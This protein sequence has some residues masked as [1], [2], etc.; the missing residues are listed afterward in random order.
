MNKILYATIKTLI[1][2]VFLIGVNGSVWYQ[3]APDTFDWSYDYGWPLA[4]LPFI[5]VLFMMWILFPFVGN[6]SSSIN[7]A[8]NLEGKDGS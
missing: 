1:F 5:I 2:V 3:S 6:N 4:L 7:N 8:N